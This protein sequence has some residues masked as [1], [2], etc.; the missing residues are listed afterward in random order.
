MIETVEL[1]MTAPMELRIIILV[2]IVLVIYHTFKE[3]KNKDKY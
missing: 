1:F 3:T 2:G